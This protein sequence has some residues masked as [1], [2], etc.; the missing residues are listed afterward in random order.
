MLVIQSWERNIYFVK[1]CMLFHCFFCCPSSF[2]CCCC[3]TVIDLQCYIFFC[4]T[5][6]WISHA[7][8]HISLLFGVS[9]PLR[10]CE[11]VELSSLCYIVSSHSHL[12]YAYYQYC[13]YV[14]PSLSIH[15]TPSHFWNP[16][17]LSTPVSIFLFCK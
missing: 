3:W 12:L 10:S 4:C 2:Y 7:C 13:V 6:K 8:I 1:M 16:C 17:L 11:S 14:N 5:A 9:F 15:P